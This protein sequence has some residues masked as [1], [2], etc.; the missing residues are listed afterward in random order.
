MLINHMEAVVEVLVAMVALMIILVM[1][2]VMEAMVSVA[3]TYIIH[4]WIL[5]DFIYIHKLEDR[6]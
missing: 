3:L 6:F 4:Q 1:Q 5:L 2:A